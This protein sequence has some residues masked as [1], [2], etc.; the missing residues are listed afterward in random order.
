MLWMQLDF[1]TYVH[2]SALDPIES[3]RDKYER[4]FH[5]E[6]VVTLA[7]HQISTDLHVTN[8]GLSTSP[9]L[10]FQ[11]LF[12]NY[13]RAPSNAVTVTPLQGLKY[14]DKTEATDELR[15]QPKEEKRTAVDVRAFTDSVYEGAPGTYYVSWPGDGI[16]IKTRNLKDVVVWNPQKEAGSKIGDMED[17][18][19]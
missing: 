18:G 10:E 19:W 14:Y 9:P 3:I 4:P 12:H 7:E 2:S 15:S 11:A 5:L 1:V 13:I 6:Y 8:T 17:G 16:S